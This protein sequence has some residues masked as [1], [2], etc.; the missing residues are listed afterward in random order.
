MNAFRAVDWDEITKGDANGMT[1][2]VQ[3]KIE[4]VNDKHF[5][6]KDRKIRSTDD[7]W[8]TAKKEKKGIQQ[9]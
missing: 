9:E 5:P 4:E 6:W 1:E 8:I 3:K 7:P 2:A